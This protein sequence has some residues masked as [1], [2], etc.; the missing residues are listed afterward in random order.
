MRPFRLR[1]AEGPSDARP[2]RV[3]SYA[4]WAGNQLPIYLIL[5]ALLVVLFALDGSFAQ[6]NTFVVFFLKPAVPLILLAVGQLFV[7][8]VGGF[9]L[10]VG[11]LVTFNAVVAA[12]LI[13]GDP[14]MTYPVVLMLGAVSIAVGLTNGVITTQL[15]VPSFITTLG[16]LLVLSG[17]ALAVSDGAPRGN[18]PDNFREWG[19]AGIN[20]VPIVDQVPYALLVLLPLVAVAWFLLHRSNYGRRVFAV[21]GND[22]AA[23]LAGIPVKR[24]RVVAFVI[25]ALFAWVAG[26]LLA[27]FT[28]ISP[29][30]GR[31]LE[32]EAIAA[33]VLG[34]AILGGGKGTVPAAMAG[35]LSLTTLFTVLNLLGFDRP[36]RVTV[37]GLI[38]IGAVA[39]AAH[40]D[41][42][43][44]Q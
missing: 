19:R 17:A 9:D 13:D 2:A 35:A 31:G 41:R 37:Q 1:T 40:R 26:L 4:R 34:G 43:L 23:G 8:V 30:I 38:L 16:M 21:G 42:R 11:A 27:G 7:I 18:L 5:V 39:F 28:G 22:R 15:G 32:F 6:P 12:H 14:A 20:D 29:D 36:L 10:S 25:S 44:T 24:V 3:R 33:V